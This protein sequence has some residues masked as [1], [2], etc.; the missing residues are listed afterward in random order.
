MA[1]NKVPAGAE[2]F[3][4]KIET[5]II[6]PIISLLFVLALAYFLWGIFEFVRNSSSDEGRKTGIKH[7]TWGIIGLFVMVSV[8]GIISIIKN[9]IGL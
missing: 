8:V 1:A 4:S 7:M 6:Q 2:S 9:S 3:I 5:N